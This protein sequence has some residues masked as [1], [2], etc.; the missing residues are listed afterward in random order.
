MPNGTGLKL[1]TALYYTPSGRSIHKDRKLDEIILASMEE[2]DSG[3]SAET[4]QAQQDSLK[5]R[6]KFLT[7]N[8]RVVYGGGGIT[9]D[10]I[11]K[12]KAV[13]NYAGQLF[14]QSV[15]FEF[16]ADY[17]DA[18]PNLRRDF[19]VDD[20][21]MNEFKTYVDGN[22]TFSYSIPGKASLDKFR[23]SLK[24]ENYNGALLSQVDNLEKSVAAERD[25][26]FWAHSE[27][28]KRILKR[29]IASTKFGAAER[30]IASKDFDVQLQKAI[31]V[32]N[33]PGEYASLLTPGT[34]TG[35]RK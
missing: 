25:K 18:H 1:T 34:K 31:E 5:N 12:E 29:E 27:T 7:D 14:A 24:R 9:P 26:D 3:E 33:N 28:I 23:E 8:K 11:V 21:L 10:I 19:V 4:T 30:T 15:F 16:A 35:Q 13:G 6:P 17:A 20:K 2:D 22:K 32:L